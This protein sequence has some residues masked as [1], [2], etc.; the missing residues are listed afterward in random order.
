MSG[1]MMPRAPENRQIQKTRA[2]LLDA[3]GCLLLEHGYADIRIADVIRK[4][5]VGRSTFYEH[6]RGKD[7]LLR[8]SLGRFLDGLADAVVEAPD[9]R[10]VTHVL[11]HFRDNRAVARGL[12]NGPSAPQVVGVLARLIEERLVAM[13]GASSRAPVISLELAS[14]Q[15]AESELGL[16]R[17]WLNRGASSGAV[18]VAKTMH[19]TGRASARALFGR[20]EELKQSQKTAPRPAYGGQSTN[21]SALQ[22]CALRCSKRVSSTGFWT[23]FNAAPVIEANTIIVGGLDGNLYRSPAT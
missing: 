22:A 4:A 3:F 20:E 9:I 6:F 1:L 11:E 23:G 5:N 15:A 2:A 10:K 7:D 21:R 14:L 17:A 12:L 13:R 8:H 16:I 18:E 19:E